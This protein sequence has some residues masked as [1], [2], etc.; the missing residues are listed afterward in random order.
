MNIYKISQ[1]EN[2]GYDTYDSAIVIAPTEEAAKKIHPNSDKSYNVYNK[3]WWKEEYQFDCWATK[4]E[5]VKVELIGIAKKGMKEGV[6]LSSFN[7]G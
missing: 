6:I 4:L 1:E 5:N 7:A 3:N 2:T